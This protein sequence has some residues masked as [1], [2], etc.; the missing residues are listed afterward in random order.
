MSL[1]KLCLEDFYSFY[2]LFNLNLKKW[3]LLLF[4]NSKF[5]CV[6]QLTVTKWLFHIFTAEQQYT[7]IRGYRKQFFKI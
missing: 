2:D 5:K 7:L 4:S 6:K 1:Y 3:T